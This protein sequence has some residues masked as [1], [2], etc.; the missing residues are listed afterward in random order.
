[1]SPDLVYELFERVAASGFSI[2]CRGERSVSSG[3]ACSA[4]EYTWHHVIRAGSGGSVSVSFVGSFEDARAMTAECLVHMMLDKLRE[5]CSTKVTV[6]GYHR[7]PDA[8]LGIGNHERALD[9][10]DDS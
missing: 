8:P 2:T 5:R 9:R 1:M 4:S 10:G 7:D 3:Q 6:T